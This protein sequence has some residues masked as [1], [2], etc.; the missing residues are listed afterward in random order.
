MGF[1]QQTL[2]YQREKGENQKQIRKMVLES[3]H[4]IAAEKN[5]T[6]TSFL[7]NWRKDLKFCTIENTVI[8]IVIGF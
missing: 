4:D 1:A 2:D 6:V 3:Y 7:K 8:K 5:G